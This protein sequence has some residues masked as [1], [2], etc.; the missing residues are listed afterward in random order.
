MADL[1]GFVTNQTAPSMSERTL[2]ETLQRQL[3]APGRRMAIVLHLSRLPPPAPRPH[4]RR[5]AR[6]LL[7]ETAQLH[8]G[9]MFSLRN[10]DLVLLCNASPDSARH[11][12][13]RRPTCVPP[14]ELPTIMARL[15]QA[16]APDPSRLITSWTLRTD[17]DA[18]LAYAQAR[19]EETVSRLETHDDGFG[20]SSAVA[21]LVR[22]IQAE[23]SSDLLHRQTAVLLQ[24]EARSSIRPLFFELTFSVQALAIRAGIDGDR[25]VRDPFLLRHLAEQLDSRLRRI[26]RETMFAPSPLRQMRRH[27]GPMLHINLTLPGAKPDVIAELVALA[28]ADIQTLGVEI[29]LLDACADLDRF[30]QVRAT[31][32]QAGALV[33][34]DRVS[35]LT[36]ALADLTCL[37][38]DLI[39]LDWSPGMADQDA[40]TKAPLA[41]ALGAIGLDRL[42]LQGADVEAALV[43]GLGQGI[44][45]FQG[46]H[47]DAILAAERI[48]TCAH[49]VGCNLTQCAERAAATG[50]AG[51]MACHNLPLLDG[52]T[53]HTQP[54]RNRAA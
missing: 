34:L 52:A 25:P 27:A 38:A 2:L 18:V 42:V 5:I 54:Y 29:S 53:P 15:M 3:R 46:R 19:L 40:P 45:R 50:H 32:Q 47:V 37:R 4:H 28:R 31:L 39:K 9:Q 7:Q 35:H 33:V 44:R 22:Q 49:A 16:D 17:A 11:P 51:R 14:A 36:L 30:H 8:D 6:A 23:N 1:G 24:G 20:D 21:A 10:G 26:L 13:Q 48:M 12:A 43:W 41:T